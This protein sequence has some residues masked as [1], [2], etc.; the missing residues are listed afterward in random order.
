MAVANCP[1]LKFCQNQVFLNNFFSDA[2]RAYTSSRV[3]E[4]NRPFCAF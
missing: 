2:N 1:T 3:V 4:A